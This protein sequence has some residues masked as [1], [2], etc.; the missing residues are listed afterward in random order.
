MSDAILLT[1]ASG[2]VGMELLAQLLE[3]SDREVI[4]VIRAEDDAHA[5]ERLEAV[6][7]TLYDEP[8][9]DHRERVVAVAGDV[10]R[11]G[12]G[13]GSRAHETVRTRVSDV[14]HCAA[15]ISFDLPIAQARA[16][17]AAGTANVLVLANGLPH[18]RQL[19]HVSTAYV[20]G[21]HAGTFRETDRYVGQRFRNSYEESKL[22]AEELVAVSGLPATVVRPS[23]V[24]GDQRSGW[25]NAF[26]V[27]YWPLQAFARGLLDRVPARRDGVVDVIPVDY[28]AGAIA[29]L[30]DL[31]G[32][33]HGTLNLVAGE[34]ASSVDELI[35]LG[36]KCFDRPAPELIAL[37]DRGA[38]LEDARV[39][40]PYFD[41][42]TRFDDARARALLEPAGLRAPALHEY[43]D[44]LMAYARGTRWGKRPLSREAA[45]E[46]YGRLR[47]SRSWAETHSSATTAEP[48]ESSPAS[49]VAATISANL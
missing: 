32:G 22:D 48:S 8:R 16:I 5:G 31:D 21:R 47:P 30:L 18:L 17:N 7:R 20:S 2:F 43:F 27:L 11:R 4:A 19:V 29:H 33:G 34:R 44:T 15:S 10:E 14:V 23:I 37:H 28:V 42:E 1:G 39:Y 45:R 26:N 36:T 46:R 24:V 6:L 38:S 3:G 49:T 40:V 35:A 9:S 25:T 41:V 13:L 12:L